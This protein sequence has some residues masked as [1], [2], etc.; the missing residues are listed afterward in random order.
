MG[1]SYISHT[2][3]Y[4][5]YTEAVAQRCFVKKLFLEISQNSQESTCDRVSLLI[6]E[7]LVQVFSSE[8]CKISKN[9]FSYRT[10]PLAASVYTSEEYSKLGDKFNMES[11]LRKY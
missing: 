2:F 10:P 4:S 3:S 9:I 11:F 7:T 6:K 8:F 1:D 5:S